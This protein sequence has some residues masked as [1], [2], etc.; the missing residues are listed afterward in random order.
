MATPSTPWKASPNKTDHLSKGYTSKVLFN[1]N[2]N[3]GV[4]VGDGQRII[5]TIINSFGENY[6]GSNTLP[7]FYFEDIDDGRCFRIS[8][9][10]FKKFD[11]QAIDVTQII[12][13][14]K[15]GIDYTVAAQTQTIGMKTVVGETL[16]K[17]EIYINE[18]K[19][20]G[21]ATNFISGVGSI[22]F[23]EDPNG[24]NAAMLSLLGV[25][26]LGGLDDPFDLDIVNNC[27]ASIR[28]INVMI[29]EI[30]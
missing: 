23:A 17:Y 26:N 29:E 4:E 16:C 14:A 25:I 2:F 27:K 8:M 20:V 3:D 9:Y 22:F 13:D 18:Y 30:S 21:T 11:G 15:D 7:P 19:D 10:F 28:V 1:Y 6:K 5:N 12:R 24:T